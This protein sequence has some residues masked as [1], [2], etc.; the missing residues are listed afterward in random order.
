[1]LHVRHGLV[2]N[3]NDAEEDQ[4][5]KHKRT[6]SARRVIALCLKLLHLFCLFVTVIAVF[7]LYLLY[8]GSKH[9][10]IRHILLLLYLKRQHCQLDYYG[11]YQ[12]RP[13]EIL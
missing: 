11:K 4:H 5:S 2:Y 1:M 9:L 8:L 3:I 13:A 7:L 6:A 10:R 12:Y